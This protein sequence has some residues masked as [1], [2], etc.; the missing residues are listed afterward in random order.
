[1]KTIL[2]TNAYIKNYT[3]SE[4]D[5]I[6]IAKHFIDN[7]YHV[8]IFTLEKEYP[9]LYDVD[10]RIRVINYPENDLLYEHYDYIWAHHYPLLDYILFEKNIKANYIHYIS[11]SAYEGFEAYPD[12]YKDLSLTSVLSKEAKLKNIEEGYIVENINIFPNYINLDIQKK[13]YIP[14][15]VLKKICIVSNHIPKELEYIKKYFEEENINVE[16][17]GKDHTYQLI[18]PELLCDYDLVISIGKTI[19]LA[20]GL[21]IPC[22]VYDRF[23]GDGYI[24][25]NNIKNSFE[26]NFSGRYLGIKYS[27]LELV[28]KIKLGYFECI[29]DL[30]ECKKFAQ[31]NFILEKIIDNAFE[32]MH[33]KPMNY[34]KF[35]INNKN[36]FRKSPIFVRENGRRQGEIDSS[37]IYFQVYYSNDG[38]YNENN[39]IK[40]YLK[41]NM[42]TFNMPKNYKFNKYRIDLTNRAGFK[43]NNLVIN[44]KKVTNLTMFNHSGLI[45]L[46]GE[47][48]CTDNDPWIELEDVGNLEL[49]YKIKNINEDYISHILDNKKALETLITSV[50]YVKGFINPKLIILMLGDNFPKNIIFKNEHNKDLKITYYKCSSEKI[51]LEIPFKTKRITCY[52]DNEENLLFTYNWSRA[53]KIKE[54]LFNRK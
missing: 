11:L 33:Q 42:C 5:T 48:I 50:K 44:K 28:E 7:G 13:I 26:Y 27:T 49:S 47:L 21:G 35:Y 46:N 18:T 53:Q 4:I 22:F 16:I 10:K 54:K 2:M 23:G 9:L 17:Y 8:D 41:D 24:L 19:N 39:S 32:L 29:N 1:M 6:T 12:Y 51:I 25:S 36:L 43:I 31:E 3:G 38:K 37:K 34:D 45:S 40:L 15:K 52:Y 14:N 30:N 20:I